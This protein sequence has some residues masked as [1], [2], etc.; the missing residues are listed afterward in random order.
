LT[1]HFFVISN[2]LQLKLIFDFR[3]K[4]GLSSRL[5]DPLDLITIVWN[6]VS[7]ETLDGQGFIT[8]FGW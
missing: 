2:S 4:N 6:V 8:R 7:S 3:P 1:L 5:Q